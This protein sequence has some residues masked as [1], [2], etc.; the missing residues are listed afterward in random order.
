MSTGLHTR[1]QEFVL[2]ALLRA[3]AE[4]RRGVFEEGQQAP[5]HQLKVLGSTVFPAGYGAEP[6][7][8]M[9]LQF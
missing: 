1:S 8:Q 2:V 5:S 6:Q 4:S 7:P 9:H 3:K